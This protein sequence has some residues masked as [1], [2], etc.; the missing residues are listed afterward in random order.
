MKD[1]ILSVENLSVRAEADPQNHLLEHINFQINEGKIVTVIGE[2]GSGKS[3]TSKALLD[4]L[5]KGIRL[6]TGSVHF[7]GNN[8]YTM[9]SSEKRQLLGTQIGFVFQDTFGSFDPM[10]T[11]GQHF[12]ELF[13]AHTTLSKQEA[14]KRSIQLLEQMLLPQPD[15][16]YSSYPEEL[17]GGM[18]QRVQLALA[19]SLEPALLIADEPTTALDPHIQAEM[20]HLMKE[21]RN[22]TGG[23]ILLITHDLGVVAEMADEVIVMKDGHIVESSQVDQLFS[24]PAH[25]H[26]MSLLY[27]YHQLLEGG[28]QSELRG[29]NRPLLTVKQTSQTYSKRHLF[30]KEE[31]EAVKQASLT[32]HK[33]EIFGL[34]GASGSGKSTLSRL[35]LHLEK[36]IA[37]EINWYGDTP[38]RKGIQWVHQDPIASFDPRWTVEQIIGEGADYWNQNPQEKHSKIAEAVSLVGLDDKFLPL[39]PYE[40]SGGM[41]QRVALARALL[42]DPELLILDEPFAS[43]DLSSQSRMLGLLQHINETRG[44]AI[45]F[46][47]HD[48]RAAIAMCNRIAVMAAGELIETGTA[49]D[50]LHSTMIETKRLVSSILTTIP[51]DR[52]SDYE[53]ERERDYAYHT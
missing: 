29:L 38:V 36:P 37:G 45:L 48:I 23:S 19:L 20:L 27:H 26:T 50:V 44:T 52:K 49:E 12:T 5:P 16:I 41:R 28:Q 3:L 6:S 9:K 15:R 8:V 7:K 46:I 1:P 42:L 21:W 13:S 10:R 4:L 2:S 47:S 34:I 17:S 40:L 18:R 11:I 32:I 33:N 43:L 25:P 53:R 14:K 22:R 31:V 24:A 51:R 30:R 39:F 35:L